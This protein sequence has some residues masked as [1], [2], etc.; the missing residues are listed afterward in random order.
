MGKGIASGYVPAEIT[1]C[2]NCFHKDVCGDKDYLTENKCCDF[3]DA[4]E[5]AALKQESEKNLDKIPIVEPLYRNKDGVP[6]F[7]AEESTAAAD[8]M[9]TTCYKN[10]ILAIETMI[11][12]A[13][14]LNAI[15]ENSDSAPLEAGRASWERKGILSSIK[16]IVETTGIIKFEDLFKSGWAALA[17]MEGEDKKC[18]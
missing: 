12:K 13:N 10:V 9:K 7:P 11:I 17:A 4:E 5:L 6:V 15:S 3:A 16:T 18:Q 2:G 8:N 1:I 14:E